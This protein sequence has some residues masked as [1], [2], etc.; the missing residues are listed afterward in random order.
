MLIRA[1][2]RYFSA[3][4]SVIFLLSFWS[5]GSLH[6]RWVLLRSWTTPVVGFAAGISTKNSTLISWSLPTVCRCYST[7]LHMH[8][9]W[10]KFRIWWAIFIFVNR[11]EAL[12][13]EALL[14]AA[15]FIAAFLFIQD[16]YSPYRWKIPAFTTGRLRKSEFHVSTIQTR[17]RRGS[18]SL[19]A[20]TCLLI[21]AFRPKIVT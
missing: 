13:I 16:N 8:E 9:Q 21:P 14:V 10:D 1:G 7:I 6:H 19:E 5:S 3:A 4:V 20:L 2:P 12:S 18:F 15:Q 11:L 17:P